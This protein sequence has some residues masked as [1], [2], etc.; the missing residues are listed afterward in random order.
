MA[1]LVG[2]VGTMTAGRTL[3][4]GFGA[5]IITGLGSSAADCVYVANGAFGLTMI[6]EF[7]LKYET[8][9]HLFGGIILAGIIL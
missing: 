1:V 3:N 9:V 4:H 6:S 2:A 8:V 5:G 7:L